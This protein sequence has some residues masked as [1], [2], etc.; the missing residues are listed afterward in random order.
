MFNHEVQASCVSNWLFCQ[1]CFLPPVTKRHTL[2]LWHPG[3]S[4]HI[5]LLL[6]DSVIYGLSGSLIGSLTLC[7][8]GTGRVPSVLGAADMSCFILLASSPHYN[9]FSGCVPTVVSVLPLQA[10]YCTAPHWTCQPSCLLLSVMGAENLIFSGAVCPAGAAS[11]LHQ[12]VCWSFSKLA[13][14]RRLS[15]CLTPHL[16]ATTPLTTSTQSKH[17]CSNASLLG[18]P[19]TCTL[20]GPLRVFTG[21]RN[22][23]LSAALSPV[24]CGRQVGFCLPAVV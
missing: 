21:L 12:A 19:L 3:S 15:L 6:L 22:V 16:C 7:L 9:V 5:Y 13:E 17:A 23:L 11:Q 24:T 4:L 10:F 2:S 14:M 1:H 20:M 8:H 18:S